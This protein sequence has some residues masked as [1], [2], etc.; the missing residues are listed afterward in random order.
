MFQDSVLSLE[1][2]NITRIDVASDIEGLNVDCLLSTLNIKKIRSDS[3]SFFKGTIYGGSK[4]KMRI[5]DKVKEI[6]ARKRKG[7]E[8]I[9]YEEG[10]LE[11]GKDHTRFEVEIRNP[12]IS[13]QDLKDDPLQFASYFDRLEFIRIG[14]GDG[15]GIM[16]FKY[17]HINRKLRRQLEEFKD[18]DLVE[19]IKAQHKETLL[20]WFEGREPF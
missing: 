13:L 1:D 5:Y 12:G 10:L 11:S 17:K 14:D 18:V 19:K 7:G 2:F 3:F 15:S 20:N 4:V 8:I 9:E 6:K 16:Q